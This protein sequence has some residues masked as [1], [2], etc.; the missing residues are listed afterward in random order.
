MNSNTKIMLNNKVEIPIVGLGL[1]RANTGNETQN[2]V[3]WALEAG[4]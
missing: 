2:A 4:Y 3:L 1:F